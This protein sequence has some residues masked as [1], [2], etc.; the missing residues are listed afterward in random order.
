MPQ[1]IRAGLERARARMR[2]IYTF[3]PSRASWRNSEPTA[4]DVVHAWKDEWPLSD[5]ELNRMAGELAA[6]GYVVSNGSQYPGGRYRGFMVWKTRAGG[7]PSVVDVPFISAEGALKDAA[8]DRARRPV[9][10]VLA[11]I[12]AFATLWAGWALTIWLRSISVS[13]DFFQSGLHTRG[14]TTYMD[15]SRDFW[16]WALYRLIDSGAAA[17]LYP[18][19]LLVAATA[20]LGALR[21]GKRRSRRWPFRRCSVRWASPMP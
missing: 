20:L 15:A 4:G 8:R 3:A 7:H 21:R 19:A 9:T 6:A 2:S 5:A 16:G 11:A 14:E 18:I 13:R 12:L 10:Y 1:R 17:V